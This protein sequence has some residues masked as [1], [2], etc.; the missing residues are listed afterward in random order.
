MP[1]RGNGD[2]LKLRGT[3]DECGGY[4]DEAGLAL[5][6]GPRAGLSVAGKSGMDGSTGDRGG[7]EPVWEGARPD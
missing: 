1:G 6:P 5:Y 7:C 4:M 2:V 3:G